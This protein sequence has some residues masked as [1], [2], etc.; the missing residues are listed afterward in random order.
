[1]KEFGIFRTLIQG[2]SLLVDGFLGIQNRPELRNLRKAETSTSG[3]SLPPSTPHSASPP[4][5]R[6][7]LG[8]KT[9][10]SNLSRR[11]SNIHFPEPPKS[12]MGASEVP[13]SSSSSKTGKG[14]KDRLGRI[15]SHQNMA[16]QSRV[17]LVR[18]SLLKDM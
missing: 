13:E 2:V 5:H 7:G 6:R 16:F 11:S 10:H 1:M 17:F 4:S 18:W 14:S 15:A 8:S 3:S 9:T 12:I